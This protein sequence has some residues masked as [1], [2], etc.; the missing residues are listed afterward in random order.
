MSDFDNK[1][2]ANCEEHAVCK[3][4]APDQ[5]PQLCSCMAAYPKNE[6]VVEK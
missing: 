6:E 4:R 5:Q 3:N 2:V 1:S